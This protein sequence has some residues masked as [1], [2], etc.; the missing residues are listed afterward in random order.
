MVSALDYLG[1][2]KEAVAVE[3][4]MARPGASKALRDVLSRV[5]A[6][7]NRMCNATKRHRIDGAKKGLILNLLLV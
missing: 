4:R 5:I 7:Y 1:A 2:M 3:K 6:E